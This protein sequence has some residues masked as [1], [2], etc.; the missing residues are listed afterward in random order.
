MDDQTHALLAE[1]IE[2]LRAIKKELETKNRQFKS[3]NKCSK[4]DGTGRTDY[5]AWSQVDCSAC[6]GTGIG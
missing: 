5:G 3:A 4:C 1:A 6:N 2:I